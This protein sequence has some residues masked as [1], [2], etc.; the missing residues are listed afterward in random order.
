[1]ALVATTFEKKAGI[2]NAMLL[3]PPFLA[4]AAEE[5]FPG[6]VCCAADDALA[7]ERFGGLEDFLDMDDPCRL[8]PLELHS[9][10]LSMDEDDEDEDAEDEEDE[11]DEDDEDGEDEDED[12]DE[13]SVSA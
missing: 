9:I 5:S 11:E 12:E 6:A 13:E 8:S 10:G 3:S 2:L 7:L 1:M 4:G